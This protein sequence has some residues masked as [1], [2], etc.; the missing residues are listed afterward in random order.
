MT[1]LPTNFVFG[2]ASSAH[3]VRDAIASCEYKFQSTD[4]LALL[5]PLS[6]RR[7]QYFVAESTVVRATESDYDDD[8]VRPPNEQDDTISNTDDHPF[9]AD[10]S[11]IDQLEWNEEDNSESMEPS[12]TPAP[13]ILRS[14][15]ER[16]LLLPERS[17]SPT[18]G[19]AQEATPLLRK[20]VSFYMTPHPR[21]ASTLSQNMKSPVFVLPEQPSLVTRPHLRRSSTS[22]S[23]SGKYNH[24][25]QSTFGQTVCMIS[26]LCLERN[27]CIR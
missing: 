10:D 2:S 14:S 26:F 23:H 7:A 6:D 12:R 24:G 18:N 22:S 19:L 1:S 13:Q 21:R 3:S 9:V 8:S 4:S 15:H 17:P 11:I 16:R 27:L 5:I 25:G 20:A